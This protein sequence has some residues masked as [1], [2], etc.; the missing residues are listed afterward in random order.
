MSEKNKNLPFAYPSFVKNTQ[1]G[2]IDHYGYGIPPGS[3]IYHQGMSLRDYFAANA[4]RSM[5]NSSYN[6]EL[7][8]TNAYRIADAMLKE[9]GE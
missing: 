8:A 9:R 1:E 4:I 6:V 3:T 7:I 5:M 2:V